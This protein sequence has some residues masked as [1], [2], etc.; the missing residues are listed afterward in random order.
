MDNPLISLVFVH[1][2]HVMV[3]QERHSGLNTKALYCEY[4][5]IIERVCGHYRVSIMALYSEYIGIIEIH[6]FAVCHAVLLF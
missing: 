6:L 1:R 5:G 3:L 2:L 4:M